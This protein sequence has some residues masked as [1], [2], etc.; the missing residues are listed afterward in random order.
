LA[1]SVLKHLS[2][3]AVGRTLRYNELTDLH[4]QVAHHRDQGYP[5]RDLLRSVVHSDLFRKK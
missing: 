5:L 3:Y 4:T 1:F 2:T